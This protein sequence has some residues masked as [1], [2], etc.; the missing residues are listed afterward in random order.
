MGARPRL[1]RSIKERENDLGVRIAGTEIKEG[2]T[3]RGCGLAVVLGAV[4]AAPVSGQVTL[5]RRPCSECDLAIES[6]VTLGEDEGPGA[7]G[8]FL[9]AARD[10]AGNVL[11]SYFQ[12]GGK[13]LVFDRSGRYVRTVGREG[14]APGEYRYIRHISTSGSSVYIWDSRG[15]RITELKGADSVART[16]TIHGD[17]LSVAVLN[18]S[19]LVYNAVIPTT[20]RIGIPFHVVSLGGSPPRSLGDEGEPFRPDIG[21]AGWRAVARADD[22]SFWAGFTT[23]Y[24]L[25]RWNVDGR[26]LGEWVREAAWF[27]PHLSEPIPDSITPPAPYLIDIAA[28]PGGRLIV[29]IAVADEEW[30]EG[31]IRSPVPEGTGFTVGDYNRYFDTVVELI[32]PGRASLL[33]TTRVDEYLISM[34]DSSHA[35][36]YR[37]NMQGFPRADV[38]RFHVP[39]SNER[40]PQ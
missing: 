31:V 38:W 15:R 25:Q 32:D 22:E 28:S 20:D 3:M 2:A 10:S 29:L 40:M 4:M 21:F 6:V 11:V 33:G 16:A 1:K 9:Q 24:R 17:P 18:D 39:D 23:E 7:L 14:S 30:Q 27:R 5:L 19:T 12:D 8:S 13:F 34:L 35:I 26:K 37:E 36:S